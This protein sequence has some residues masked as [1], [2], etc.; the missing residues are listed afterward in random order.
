MCQIFFPTF[1]KAFSLK[2]N[3]CLFDKNFFLNKYD[4]PT[5]R[6][7]IFEHGKIVGAWKCEISERVIIKK[8]KHPKTTVHN[9]IVAYKENKL[10]IF[11]LQVGKPPVLTERNV[12]Y[13]LRTLR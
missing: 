11:Q 5:Q 12:H 13:L 7:S 1:S 9:V 4:C 2:Y 3:Y 6:A 8:L 10:E